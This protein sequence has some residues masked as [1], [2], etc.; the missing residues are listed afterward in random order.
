M[1][2]AS[3]TTHA[4]IAP[5]VSGRDDDEDGSSSGSG[6]GS[7]DSDSDAEVEVSPKKGKR[8]REDPP[9]TPKASRHKKVTVDTELLML[10]PR[11]GKRSKIDTARIIFEEE[12]VRKLA[13]ADPIPD[14][15]AMAGREF[16]YESRANEALERLFGFIGNKMIPSKPPKDEKALAAD[17]GRHLQ[18]S[19]RGGTRRQR[20]RQRAGEGE[21]RSAGG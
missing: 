8:A 11:C 6:S 21:A 16:R 5:G 10:V 1:R 17:G 14:D 12:K 9:P 4:E 7:E 15:A 19:Q 2:Q 18:R 13:D 20:R 3:S